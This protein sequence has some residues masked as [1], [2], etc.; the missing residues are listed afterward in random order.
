[1]DCLNHTFAIN[2]KAP[3]LTDDAVALDYVLG[4]LGCAV[5]FGVSKNGEAPPL[6]LD[7]V[8]N[9]SRLLFLGNS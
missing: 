7:V 9:V 2:E 4:V 8:N 5:G 3:G 1:M 6:L